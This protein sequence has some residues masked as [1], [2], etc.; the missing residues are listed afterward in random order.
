MMFGATFTPGVRFML[1]GEEH[2][3]ERVNLDETLQIQSTRTLS[4]RAVQREELLSAYV[5]SQLRFV[6]E[7]GS[8]AKSGGKVNTDD[9]FAT[10]PKALRDEAERRRAYVKA[11]DDA[12]S[13][14]RRAVQ[15]VIDA[16]ASGRHDPRKPGAASVL[17][18]RRRLMQASGDMRALIPRTP[19]RGNYTRKVDPVVLELARTAVR[20]KYMVPHRPSRKAAYD[21]LCGLIGRYNKLH[22][23]ARLKRPG[24]KVVRDVIEEFTPYERAVARYGAER[25]KIMF[26]TAL[27]GVNA[28]RIAE[29]YELDHTL[30]DIFVLDDETGLP[31][32]RAWLSVVID[33]YSR[34]IVGYHIG[35]EPPS[36]AS[37]LPCLK[38]AFLPKVR[39][40]ASNP[41][42]Q[43][44]WVGYGTCEELVLDNDVTHHGRAVEDVCLRL[45][46]TVTYAKVKHPWYKAAVERF[47][48][49]LAS[50][51][52]HLQQGTT[53]SNIFERDEYDPAKHAV[54]RFSAL[55]RLFEKWVVDVYACSIN[56][57]LE[58]APKNK[59]IEGAKIDPP[60]LP[61][62]P[63]VL[64]VVLGKIDERVLGHEGV[65]INNLLYNSVGLGEIRRRCG[66]RVK[67]KVKWDPNDLGHAH[68]EDPRTHQF[69]MA[70]ALRQDYAAGLT[71]FQHKAVRRFQALQAE[72]G[73]PIE[74]V[75]EA[76]LRL[77]ELVEEE[78]R[79]G[80]RFRTRKAAARYMGIRS[81]AQ[82]SSDGAKR[83]TSSVPTEEAAQAGTRAVEL[84]PEAQQ[85]LSAGAT[86]PAA[87]LAVD[88]GSGTIVDKV[89]G[90]GRGGKRPTERGARPRKQT[91]EDADGDIPEFPTAAE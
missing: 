45:D 33:C 62:D 84:S 38:H 14:S 72:R 39:L 71:V 15:P 73:S 55:V 36:D 23:D 18:W 37:V 56:R 82:N 51:F 81:G 28:T 7:R 34:Y 52:L 50:T 9:D 29:R 19:A 4:S 2:V 66:E 74:D 42:C 6:F 69:V 79:H 83:H 26:R 54:V 78:I 87:E 60:R 58:D 24:M 22:P 11:L 41:E 57:T 90:R 25:A 85:I 48:G 43:N 17:R 77:T 13:L 44:D 20:E 35:F 1:N 16:V 49:T 86:V 59:W 47:F 75:Y 31:L 32:G 88:A 3:V 61:P 8:E 21:H 67:V 10:L 12:E 70:P 68:V 64:D 80:R 30:T 63:A 5:T 53:F 40:K 91:M 46:I 89:S 65:L 76:K 27:K